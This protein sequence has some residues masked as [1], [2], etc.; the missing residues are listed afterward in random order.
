MRMEQGTVRKGLILVID[1]E[2]LVRELLVTVLNEA[3][4]DTHDTPD[5]REALGMVERADYDLL[6][7]DI[8]MPGMDGKAFFQALALLA[9]D[10]AS[11]TVFVT[12]DVGNPTTR[13]FLLKAGRP[14]IAKPFD[15]SALE[16]LVAHEL[17]QHPQAAS[18]CPDSSELPLQ[19]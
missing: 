10:M 8:N 12:G 3:G 19:R 2:P 17:A 9:P 15:I 5:A 11:R 14:V 6:V 7:V 1:D 13:D 16:K 4:Y 18:R